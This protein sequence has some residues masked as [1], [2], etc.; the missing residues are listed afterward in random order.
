MFGW[1][2]WHAL[3]EADVVEHVVHPMNPSYEP[4][5][6]GHNPLLIKN[7]ESHSNIPQGSSI[8]DTYHEGCDKACPSKFA[9][10]KIPI[11][12]C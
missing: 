11:G 2:T 6:E 1:I 4:L 3:S 7:Y 5:V 8:C 12:S 10:F 9:I